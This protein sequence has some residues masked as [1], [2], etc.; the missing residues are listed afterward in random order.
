MLLPTQ[1][2][3]KNFLQGFLQAV[4]ELVEIGSDCI[5]QGCWQVGIGISD[6]LQFLHCLNLSHRLLVFDALAATFRLHPLA[7]AVVPCFAAAA[8]CVMPALTLAMAAALTSADGFA[9][10]G[11]L[12]A[13]FAA[14]ALTSSAR[15]FPQV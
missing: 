7:T 6:F 12:A 3:V 11:A 14:G 13:D 9:F 4:D 15:L 8:D 5:A 10:F 2:K 1:T